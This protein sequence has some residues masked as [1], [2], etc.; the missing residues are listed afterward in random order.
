MQ[1]IK[2]KQ[3][4]FGGTNQQ[5]V[6]GDG[7]LGRVNTEQADWNENNPSAEA[8]VKNRTHYVDYELTT[9]EITDCYAHNDGGEYTEFMISGI[10]PNVVIE[11]TNY[12]KHF[13]LNNILVTLGEI[14]KVNIDGDEFETCGNLAILNTLGIPERFNDTGEDF[15]LIFAFGILFL[16]KQTVF[17]TEFVNGS[18]GV[19]VENVHTLDNKFLEDIPFSKIANLHPVANTGNYNDLNSRPTALSEFTNDRNFITQENIP[20]QQ[21][22]DWNE[23]NQASPAF[24][25]N[26]PT[27]ESRFEVLNHDGTFE[28]FSSAINAMQAGKIYINPTLIIIPPSSNLWYNTKW[29]TNQ[30]L[31]INQNAILISACE[32]VVQNWEGVAYCI[33]PASNFGKDSVKFRLETDGWEFVE[34]IFN[35]VSEN[36]IDA[37]SNLIVDDEHHIPSSKA[38]LQLISNFITLQDVP[39]GQEQADWNQTAVNDPSYIKNKPTI[40]AAQVNS[41]WNS[42]SG[43]SQILNKPTLSSVATS[44]SYNDLS[45][46]PDINAKADK[47]SNA[48]NNHLASLDSNGNLKDSGYKGTDFFTRP[49]SHTSGSLAKIDGSGNIASSSILE[50]QLIA[51]MLPLVSQTDDDKILKVVNGAWTLVKPTTIYSGTSTPSANTGSDGDIYIQIAQ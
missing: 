8:Y 43:L 35:S 45:D 4:D 39:A 14:R 2:R 25:K 49:S 33:N 22:S 13:M 30:N 42:N 37:Q 46:K 6:L 10:S 31:Y 5:C 18:I 12:I 28:S 24:I 47:V 32:D 34:P 51:S 38:L 16:G 20:A 44:G 19:N 36:M 40:P 29:R 3:I 9:C 11:N 23:S 27:I 1:K 7:S 50:S 15:V 17:G 21:Q 26:K 48:T 41:D